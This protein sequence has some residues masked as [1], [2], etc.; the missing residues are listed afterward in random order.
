MINPKDFG[1]MIHGKKP[2]SSDS[3]SPAT[4]E[5]LGHLVFGGRVLG[6]PQKHTDQNTGNTSGGM[7]GRL[8]Y[9]NTLN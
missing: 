8:G 5:F 4:L 3:I 7:T 2:S 6:G 9:I 1:I